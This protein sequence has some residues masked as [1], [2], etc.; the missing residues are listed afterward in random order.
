M[1]DNIFSISWLLPVRENPN[2]DDSV[3]FSQAEAVLERLLTVETFTEDLS[4]S[5]IAVDLA[6]MTVEIEMDVRAA[7]ESEATQSGLKFLRD[8]VS[9]AE[10]QEVFRLPQ[11][12]SLR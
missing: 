4:D 12:L 7:S 3:I 8:A 11:L 2:V 10:C 9:A 6:R 5:T 1:S